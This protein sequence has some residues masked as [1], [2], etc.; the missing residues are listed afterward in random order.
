MKHERSGFLLAG[1]AG[2]GRPGYLFVPFTAVET[3]DPYAFG[4]AYG[5]RA[6]FLDRPGLEFLDQPLRFVHRIPEE[7]LAEGIE[8]SIFGIAFQTPE[9]LGLFIGYHLRVDMRPDDIN[10]PKVIAGASAAPEGL[11]GV[12]KDTLLEIY[13]DFAEIDH[14]PW[15][16]R[17][18]PGD[19][20]N[21]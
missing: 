18:K 7:V 13:R 20:T 1:L 2:K 11:P 9:E 12:K 4:H 5:T 15:S 6:L 3:L 21:P 14:R 16:L 17:A 19:A 10:L 8:G